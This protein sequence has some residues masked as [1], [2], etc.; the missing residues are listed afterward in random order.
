MGPGRHQPGVVYDKADQR[1]CFELDKESNGTLVPVV[2]RVGK[3]P[4]HI[5]TGIKKMPVGYPA[6]SWGLFLT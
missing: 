6:L 1:P 4:P 2:W 5:L 3:N